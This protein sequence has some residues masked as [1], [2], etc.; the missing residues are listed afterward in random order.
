MDFKG[1]FHLKGISDLRKTKFKLY[2]VLLLLTIWSVFS[3]CGYNFA[4]GGSF[5]AGV[6]QIFITIFENRTNEAGIEKNFTDDL[7]NEFILKR[8]TGLAKG[9]ENAD[10]ILS[11][12]ILSKIVETISHTGTVT[13]DERRVKM[14]VHMKLRNRQNRIVWSNII[15]EDQTFVIAVT[16]QGT[17]RNQ[18]EAIITLSKR[19]AE[20]AYNR[21]TTDF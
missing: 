12:V 4:G 7:V 16:K 1:L 18:R 11:G 17:E 19:F 2:S 8:E 3:A 9:R 10:A 5:P 13:S 15:T 20:K 6:Q 21:L 14:R